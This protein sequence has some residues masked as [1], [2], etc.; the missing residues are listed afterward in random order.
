MISQGPHLAGPL[1][2]HQA[3]FKYPANFLH[4]KHRLVSILCLSIMLEQARAKLTHYCKVVSCGS[5]N[6]CI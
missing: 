2:Q 1:G 4:R 3:S 5:R 6:I